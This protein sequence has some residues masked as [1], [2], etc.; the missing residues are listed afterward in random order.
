MLIK[1]IIFAA[2]NLG[3]INRKKHHDFGIGATFMIL[4]TTN[5]NFL[6]NS[7]WNSS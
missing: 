5:Y 1:N 2:W 4:N 3:L 6:L 7:L